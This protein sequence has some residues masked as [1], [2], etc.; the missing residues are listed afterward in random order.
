MRVRVWVGGSVAN[1]SRD[2]FAGRSVIAYGT[3]RE[4]LLFRVLTR[5]EAGFYLPSLLCSLVN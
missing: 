1:R 3:G 4:S 2:R 5:G